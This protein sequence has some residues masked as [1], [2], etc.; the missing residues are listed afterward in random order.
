MKKAIQ[1]NFVWNEKSYSSKIQ[2]KKKK[3]KERNALPESAPFLK[4]GRLTRKRP[5]FKKGTLC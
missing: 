3:K 1:L 2:K 5:L 4:K